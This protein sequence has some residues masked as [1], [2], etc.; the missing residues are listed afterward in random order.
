VEGALW[1]GKLLAADAYFDKEIRANAVRTNG[2]FKGIKLKRKRMGTD[3]LL[4]VHRL[5]QP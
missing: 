5:G 4:C 3:V 2:T 1:D